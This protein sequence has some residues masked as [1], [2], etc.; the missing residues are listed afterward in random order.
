MESSKVSKIRKKNS[1]PRKKTVETKDSELQMVGELL[2]G[3]LPS[4]E[5]TRIVPEPVAEEPE[6]REIPVVRE[7]PVAREIPAVQEAPVVRE[8]PIPKAAPRSDFFSRPIPMAY[9]LGFTALTVCVVVFVMQLLP[10]KT[11]ETTA[12]TTPV[13]EKTFESGA[14]MAPVP[15]TD[16]FNETSRTPEAKVAAVPVAPAAAPVVI[17]PQYEEVEDEI[18]QFNAS[19]AYVE[20]PTVAPVNA[21]VGGNVPV[22]LPSDDNYPV[23]NATDAMPQAAPVE[24]NIFTN[25]KTVHYNVGSTMDE[26]PVYHGGAP[27]NAPTSP[28]VGSQATFAAPTPR[29]LAPPPTAPLHTEADPSCPSFDPGLGSEAS[30]PVSYN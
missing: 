27:A 4:I 20:A 2:F 9:S 11:T 3:S 26:I 10:E 17:P 12:D 29:K 8:I 28:A 18:P 25:P 16:F 6:V 19:L 21:P 14:E 13:A 1:T 5:P 23:F 30:L 7:T 15:P 24:N 22:D